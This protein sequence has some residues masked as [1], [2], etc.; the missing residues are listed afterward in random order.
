M[1]LFQMPP[2][3][4]PLELP[5]MVVLVMAA[6]PPFQIPPPLPKPVVVIVL[7]LTVLLV[8]VSVP[9]FQIPSPF[10]FAELPLTSTFVSVAAAA[11]KKNGRLSPALL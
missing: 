3:S 8:S 1:L 2:P 9:P 7:S 10:P 5:L 4:S 6:L 11:G